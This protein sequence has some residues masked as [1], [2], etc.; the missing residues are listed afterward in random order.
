[1]KKPAI[2]FPGFTNPWS[3]ASLKDIAEVNPKNRNLPS[4]FHYID[5]E[6]VNSGA[7]GA[8]DIIERDHAPSR[9]QRLLQKDDILYQTVRPYQ[10][11]N[12]HFQCEGNYVA[13]T[14]YA[15]LRAHGDPGFLF[16]AIHTDAFV[17]QVMDRCTGTSYPSINGSDLSKIELAIPS[18]PEQKR[19]A[20]ALSAVD[21]KINLL[22]K[23]RDTLKRFK[24]GLMQQIFSQGVT[25]PIDNDVKVGGG[26]AVL[27]SGISDEDGS[28][29]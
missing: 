17:D 23:Q 6:S 2:R 29:G 13:S 7:L 5:L 4:E 1:M 20:D 28:I 21:A 15:Q 10:R 12:L 25:L 19:I 11:N 18:L 9:A 16:Q 26:G 8:V 24:A 27:N 14:G 22:E 3:I